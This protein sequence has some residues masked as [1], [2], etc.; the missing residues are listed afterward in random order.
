MKVFFSDCRLRLQAYDG[1]YLQ[2]LTSTRERH[3]VPKWT[4]VCFTVGDNFLDINAIPFARSTCI[5]EE[6]NAN[7]RFHRRK[8]T[9]TRQYQTSLQCRRRKPHRENPSDVLIVCISVHCAAETL[10][11]IFVKGYLR[12]K[13]FKGPSKRRVA[14]LVLLLKRYFVWESVQPLHRI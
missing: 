1:H 9:Q 8:K 5:I 11:A 10:D 14:L 13:T 7:D 4:K 6:L 2:K 3:E 12:Q